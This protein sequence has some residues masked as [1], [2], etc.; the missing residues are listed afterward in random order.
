MDISTADHVWS[1]TLFRVGEAPI[2]LATVTTVLVILVGSVIISR[3]VQRAM[4]RAFKFR[5]VDGEGTARAAARLAHYGIL[6][7]GFALAIQ[8]AG[9]NLGTLFAAG[10]IFAV[11]LGFAMQRIAQNF[12]SGVILLV[13]RSIKPG[14]VI[15]V[16]EGIVRVVEMGILT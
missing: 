14:D 7:T 13:E 15:E 6:L 12:V 2:S 5:G 16:S 9:I 11:G 10:A 3:L 1:R 4:R 8:T